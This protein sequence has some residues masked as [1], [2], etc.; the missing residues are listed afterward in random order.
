MRWA[1]AFAVLALAPIALA[2]LALVAWSAHTVLAPGGSSAAPVA[3]SSLAC[4]VKPADP[5]CDTGAGEV[6]VFRMSSTSN[7][8]AGTPGG[9]SYGNVVC[10]G[11]VTGLGTSCTGTYDTVVALSG[12]DNAHVATT[13]GGAYTTEACLSA[14]S[15]TVDCTYGA[16]CGTDYTCVATAS[17]TTNAHVADC[18]G[19]DDYATKV[20]CQVTA[21]SPCTAGSD[22]DSDGFNDEAEWWVNTDCEDNCP[23]VIGSDDA[24]PLDIDMTRDIDVTGDVFNYVGRIGAAGGR[25]SDPSCP[26]DAPMWLQRLDLQPDCTI[27]VTGDVFNYVGKIGMKCT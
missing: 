18:D 7:A 12:A 8:H 11:G 21:A 27:D 26:L 15:G 20:C 2:G 3:A 16:S 1:T 10:C 25:A 9:S 5:G 22:T 19:T 23:D 24:W 4:S 6:E 17:G 14:S 13:T